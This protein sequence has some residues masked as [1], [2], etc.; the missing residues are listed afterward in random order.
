MSGGLLAATMVIATFT[1]LDMHTSLWSIRLMM[2]GRGL[3]MGFAFVPMQAASYA[4]I[5]PAD[6]GRAS[7]IFATQRQVGISIGVAILASI[8]A[9]YMSLSEVPAPDQIDRVLT[10]YHWAFGAAVGM[11][12]LSVVAAWFIR[13]SD[14]AGTMRVRQR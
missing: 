11:S 6:N 12:L 5:A 3:C 8:L 13:D 2:F 7:S 14:A 1:T 10:G 4:T 9:S